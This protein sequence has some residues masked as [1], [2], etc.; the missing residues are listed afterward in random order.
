MAYG[1]P[2]EA[3]PNF[4]CSYFRKK[5][6]LAPYTGFYGNI[7]ASIAYSRCLGC[8]TWPEV[9]S[10]SLRVFMGF[11]SHFR[12]MQAK[13][14]KLVFSHYSFTPYDDIFNIIIAAILLTLLNHPL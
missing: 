1:L 5:K 10:S 4:L 9:V 3:T 14:S 7:S 2:E 11:L 12:K 13:N 6:N 8:K